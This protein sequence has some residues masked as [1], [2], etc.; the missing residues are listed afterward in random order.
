[1]TSVDAPEGEIP[2]LRTLLRRLLGRD[3]RPE[4][5]VRTDPARANAR[6]TSRDGT[7][8][9]VSTTSTA[10]AEEYVGRVAGDEDFSGETGA[11]RRA[12]GR[13]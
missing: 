8:Q 13:S 11:E 6:H 1:M 9:G 4:G 5:D 2:V 12:S 7:A 10:G 3:G